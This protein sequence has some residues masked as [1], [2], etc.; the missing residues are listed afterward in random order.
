LETSGLN[1][2]CPLIRSPQQAESQFEPSNN[3]NK[4]L[5]GANLSSSRKFSKMS[6]ERVALRMLGS[7]RQCCDRRGVPITHTSH[8]NACRKSNKNVRRTSTVRT[9]LLECRQ[10]RNY[11]DGGGKISV[12]FYDQLV[13]QIWP[14]LREFNLKREPQW[15]EFSVT[16]AL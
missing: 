1:W 16:M 7:E 8:I 13:R 6:P 9:L 5:Q 14:R 12:P 10:G 3:W 11:L 15:Y 4:C 2:R